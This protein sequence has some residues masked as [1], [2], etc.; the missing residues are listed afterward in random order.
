LLPPDSPELNLVEPRWRYWRQNQPGLRIGPEH[1]AIVEICYQGG[2]H[3]D[4]R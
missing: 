4:G 3:G 2:A 1:A